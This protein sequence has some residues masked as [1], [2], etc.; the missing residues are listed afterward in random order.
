[1]NLTP[2]IAITGGEERLKT[3]NSYSRFVYCPQLQDSLRLQSLFYPDRQLGPREARPIEHLSLRICAQCSIHCVCSSL[4]GILLS[5]ANMTGQTFSP[6][7]SNATL[8]L[9]LPSSPFL[10]DCCK[11]NSKP[12][13]PGIP[14]IGS[15]SSDLLFVHVLLQA[16]VQMLPPFE[17]QGVTDKFEPWGK[18]QGRIV[19]HRLQSIGSNVSSVSDF[20]QIGFKVNVC[21][22]EEDVVN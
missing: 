20:V 4:M 14:L 21:F 15:H 11:A 5:L 12:K 9:P 8:T 16:L 3:T 10:F 1:M 18:L 7:G 2:T 22:D 17:Q 13:L 6:R 19:E